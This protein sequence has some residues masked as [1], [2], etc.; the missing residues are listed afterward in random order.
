MAIPKILARLGLDK[1]DFSKKL[2]D[3]GKELKGKTQAFNKIG[4]AMSLAVTGGLV[5]AGAAL[6]GLVLKV[7]GAADELKRL[8]QVSGLSTT[9][10]QELA[11][12]GGLVGVSQGVMAKGA[13]TL[14]KNMLE[15][16][17]G[18]AEYLD[19]VEAL[20]LKITDSNGQLKSQEELFKLTVSALSGMT[21]KTERSAHAQILLGRAGKEIAPLLDEG[22]DAIAR[23]SKEAHDLGT[24]MSGDTI[25]VF[26]AFDDELFKI[27]QAFKGAGI[28]IATTLVPVLK[29][30]LFPLIKTTIIPAVVSLGKTVAGA[31]KWFTSAPPAVQGV[32]GV[33]TALAAAAGPILL[34][35]PHIIAGFKLI[36]PAALAVGKAV[37]AAVAI[38]LSP[39]AIKIG[40][41]VAALGGLGLVIYKFG[42]TIA[43][44][45]GKGVGFVVDLFIG[46][47]NTMLKGVNWFAEKVNGALGREVIPTFK[48]IPKVGKK[49]EKSI[50]SWGKAGVKQFQNMVDGAKNMVTGL[51]TMETQVADTTEEVNESLES[52]GQSYKALQAKV[53]DY[54]NASE[55]AHGKAKK[56]AQEEA[57]LAKSH[58]ESTLGRFEKR[59]EAEEKKAE[60]LRQL[61]E[62]RQ[63][64]FATEGE[65]HDSLTQ[66]ILANFGQLFPGA[67]EALGKVTDL[68]K[69][70]FSGGE[71]GILGAVKGFFT[72]EGG[73]LG[74]FKGLFGGGEGGGGIL[75]LAKG[76]FGGGGSLSTLLTAGGPWGAGIAAALKYKDQIIGAF[77]GIVSGAKAAMSTVK[78]VIGGIGDALGFGGGPQNENERRAREQRQS[79]RD[80]EESGRKAEAMRRERERQAE[81][82][83]KYGTGRTRPAAAIDDDKQQAIGAAKGFY[84]VVTKPT[85]FLAGEAGRETVDITPSM[86][87][88]GTTMVFN[89]TFNGP[90]GVKDIGRK[91]RK[92]MVRHGVGRLT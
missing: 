85:L 19:S 55:T 40:I 79:Y 51:L 43:E 1:T 67:Q 7:T 15:A 30:D 71:G 76:I 81:K 38:G 91:L 88:R 92:D 72:G 28:E 36:V 41:V 69:T 26:D 9:F 47:I 5:A 8:G 86:G 25:A 2:D 54:G 24:V 11:H 33:F 60:L 82:A 39:L 89:N 62:E 34:A 6:G 35:L 70:V 77:K 49:V 56:A 52:T 45:L 83:R 64:A 78:N 22:A 66:K 74:K 75:G 32:I 3:A 16:K 53:I 68:F 12:I 20:G 87:R 27:K 48:E 10:L 90:V 37:A 59:R 21:N 63:A 58:L 4:K 18:S 17:D 46:H 44:V 13:T 61:E 29:N 57:D 42:D 73:L 23:M 50:T 80:Y 84:G 31:I 14:A 65:A